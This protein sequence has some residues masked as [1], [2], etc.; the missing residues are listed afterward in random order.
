M[1][2][3][4]RSARE[5]AAE[6]AEEHRASFQQRAEALVQVKD[7]AA[8]VGRVQGETEERLKAARDR[9]QQRRSDLEAELKRRIAELRERYGAG[10]TKVDTWLAEVSAGIQQRRREAEL[11]AG[12]A[13][14]DALEL[15]GS[16]EAIARRTGGDARELGKWMKLA[17]RDHAEPGSSGAAEVPAPASQHPDGTAVAADDVAEPDG[18]A[19][20]QDAELE[21][22][23]Q[24]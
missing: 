23:P 1:R 17:Q 6:L 10:K 24:W 2:T 20:G 22:R 14:L 16:L 7:S 15:E 5:L 18:G 13:V 12:R 19:G 21:T 9:A 4:K 3:R 8:L 11:T